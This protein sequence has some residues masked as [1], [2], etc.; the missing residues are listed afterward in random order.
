M[1]VTIRTS[2]R[3][4]S[5]AALALAAL[6]ALAAPGDGELAQAGGPPRRSPSR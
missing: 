4:L 3:V 6:G 1:S 5:A 2:R